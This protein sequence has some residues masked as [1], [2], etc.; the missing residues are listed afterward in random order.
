LAT[1]APDIYDSHLGSNVQISIGRKVIDGQQGCPL[2]VIIKPTKI[3]SSY[4]KI[5]TEASVV[6]EV[7]CNIFNQSWKDINEKKFLL[8]EISVGKQKKQF[9]LFVS[10]ISNGKEDLIVHR[11]SGNCL[12]P[13]D[14]KEHNILDSDT[15][16]ADSSQDSSPDTPVMR[17]IIQR[18]GQ[19]K[20]REVLMQQYEKTCAIS[21]SKAVEALEAA[22]IKTHSNGGGYDCQ[23]GLLLRADIHTLY[24]LNLIGV[25]SKG[26][27]HVSPSLDGTN[28]EKYAGKSL[29]VTD[30]PIF[31]KNLGERFKEY[32][33]I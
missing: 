4:V 25:D 5:R 15:K 10:K 19:P 29:E 17:E 23:N 1:T 12:Y 28:Y 22:H 2:F 6:Q 31:K 24:D 9:E 26:T 27:V 8:S 18:R 3:Q 20:F 14:Y 32:K 7:L 16:S 33:D 21:G 11:T 30:R 13:D